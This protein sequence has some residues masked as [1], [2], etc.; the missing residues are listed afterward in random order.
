MAFIL[1]N[2]RDYR[3][4]NGAAPLASGMKHEHD[5]S[6]HEKYF[7]IKND[8][9]KFKLASGVRLSNF[10]AVNWHNQSGLRTAVRCR[11]T[12][13]PMRSLYLARPVL[14]RSVLNVP[15][16]TIEPSPRFRTQQTIQ[17]I[18]P[19]P[20]VNNVIKIEKCN[21]SRNQRCRCGCRRRRVQ[22]LMR[23]TTLSRTVSIVWCLSH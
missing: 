14:G 4:G 20:T 18:S 10:P 11:S 23:L 15:K 19:V 7:P 13:T 12:F 5:S 1:E 9:S 16:I 21:R 22:C 3:G 6:R 17:L 8:K 2:K